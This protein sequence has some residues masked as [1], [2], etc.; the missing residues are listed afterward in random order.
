MVL[1]NCKCCAAGEGCC[2]ACYDGT[3]YV[4]WEVTIP[5]LTGGCCADLQGTHSFSDWIQSTDSC[6]SLKALPN[7]CG[8]Y[9][10][11]ELRITKFEGYV[12]MSVTAFSNIS[13]SAWSALFQPLG[14]IIIS[15]L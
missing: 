11:L 13:A 6:Y 4:D 15:G 2:P 14:I 8:E 3:F 1:F 12:T 5:A 7:E 10:S 9:N